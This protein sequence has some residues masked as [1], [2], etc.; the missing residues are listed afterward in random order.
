MSKKLLLLLGLILMFSSFIFAQ[1]TITLLDTHINATLQTTTTVTPNLDWTHVGATNNKYKV[2]IGTSPSLSGATEFTLVGAPPVSVLDLSTTTTVLAYNTTYYWQVRQYNG[3]DVELANA[4]AIASFRTPK[5]S[6]IPNLTWATIAGAGN[7]FIQVSPNANFSSPVID[8][9][10]TGADLSYQIPVANALNYNT[11]YYW[12]VRKGGG[13]AV[14]QTPFTTKPLNLLSETYSVAPN[15]TVAIG[16]NIVYTA[17]TDEFEDLS[18]AQSNVS[19]TAL[20]SISDPAR[21]AIAMAFSVPAGVTSTITRTFSL[22]AAGPAVAPTASQI[23]ITNDETVTLK[24]QYGNTLI[25]NTTPITHVAFTGITA[26]AAAYG[27]ANL[28]YHTSA[29]NIYIQ[30]TTAG[31]LTAGFSERVIVKNLNNNQTLTKYAFVNG[32]NYEVTLT[33]AELNTIT[34]LNTPQRLSV[35]SYYDQI[36]KRDFIWLGDGVMPTAPTAAAFTSANYNPSQNIAVSPVG[37]TWIRIFSSTDPVGFVSNTNLDAIRVGIATVPTSNTIEAA[38]TGTVTAAKFDGTVLATA[39]I[40]AQAYTPF[41]LQTPANFSSAVDIYPRLS[42]TSAFTTERGVTDMSYYLVTISE[43]PTFAGPTTVTYETI[44]TEFYPEVDLQF[45]KS[46]FWKVNAMPAGANSIPTNITE[47]NAWVFTTTNDATNYVITSTIPSNRTLTEVNSD[48]MTGYKFSMSPATANNTTLTIE[49]GVTLKFA[50]ATK[51]VIGGN[52][53]ANGTAEEIVFTTT[54]AAIVDPGDIPYTSALWG[55]LEFKHD[56]AISRTALVTDVNN[57]YISG[58]LLDDVKIQYTTKPISYQTGAV[59]DIYIQDSDFIH[60]ENGI[61]VSANSFLKNNNFNTFDAIGTTPITEANKYA[62]RGGAYFNTQIITGAAADNRFGGLGIQTTNKNTKVIGSTITFIKGNAIDLTSVATDGVPIID[63]NTIRGTGTNAT[64]VAVKAIQGAKITRNTIGGA[65]A[66]QPNTGFAISKGAYIASNTI[67]QNGAGAILADAGATVINNTITDNA[68]YGITNGKNISNNSIVNTDGLVSTELAALRNINAIK[69]DDDATV[70]YNTITNNKGYGIFGGKI[71]SNNTIQML[72]PNPAIAGSATA[73]YAI[74]AKTGLTDSRIEYNTITNPIGFAI[75]NGKN[76]NNNTISGGGLTMDNAYGIMAEVGSTVNNN[77][78]SSMKG[79]AIE[80]GVLIH[81][82]TITNGKA[83]IKADANA[84]ITNNSLT[85]NPDAVNGLAISGGE[86]INFNTIKGYHTD[87]TNDIIASVTL[88]EFKNNTVG[89]TNASDINKSDGGSI[90]NAVKSTATALSFTDNTFLNNKY[91]NNHIKLSSK[92]LVINDNMIDNDYDPTNATTIQNTGGLISP[93]N[94][95]AGSGTALYIKLQDANATMKRNTITDHK[96]N[97]L[98]AALYIEGTTVLTDKIVI[99]DNNVISN[100]HAIDNTAKGAAVYH[101]SGIVVLGSTNP[102]VNGNTITFNSVPNTSRA[103][104][105][106]AIYTVPNGLATPTLTN[107]YMDIYRNIIASNAGNYA[108]YGVPRY[109]QYNN[110]YDN[111]YNGLVEDWILPDL[112]YGRNFYYTQATNHAN[113]TNNFWG[114][115]SDMGQIDPTISDDNEQAGVGIVTYQPILSGPST[116]TPGI[117]DNISETKVI[118]DLADIGN[119]GIVNLPTD[120]EIYVVISASDNNIYSSDFT[121]VKISN[122]STGFYIQPLLQET[123]ANTEKYVAI[124]KLDTGGV[125]NPELNILPVTGGDIIKITSVTNTS[126]TI[127]LMAALEGATSITPYI[128]T[129]DFGPWTAASANQPKKFTFTNSGT[130]PLTFAAAPTVTGASAAN[131]TIVSAPAA[132]TVIP[133]GASFDVVVAYTTAATVAAAADLVIDFTE[134]GLVNDRAIA[135]RGTTIAAWTDD[136]ATEPWGTPIPL[137]NQMTIVADVT[138]DGADPAVG[139]IVGAFVIKGM[140]EILRGKTQISNAT[141]LATIVVQTEVA[142]EEIYFKVWDVSAHALYECPSISVISSVPGGS[143]GAT[144]APA[145]IPSA[146]PVTLSGNMVDA[147]AADLPGAIVTNIHSTAEINPATNAAYEYTTD[148]NGDYSIQ[149]WNGSKVILQPSKAGYSFVTSTANPAGTQVDPNDIAFTYGTPVQTV[150]AGTVYYNT[151]DLG[152]A[153]QLLIDAE[154]STLAAAHA[155]LNFIGTIERFVVAGRIILGDGTV[156]LAN[157]IITTTAPYAGVTTDANGYF[158]FMVDS[159]TNVSLN[160]TQTNLNN[161]GYQDL[162][163]PGAIAIGVVTQDNTNTVVDDTDFGGS[164]SRT[165]EIT[166]TPGW[167]LVSLNVVPSNTTPASVFGVLNTNPDDGV[168]SYITQV[169]TT[170]TIWDASSPSTSTLSNIESGQG[171]YVNNSHTANVTLTVTGS[172]A[173]TENITLETN[174]WNLVGYTMPRMGQT[175]TMISND[176]D[177]TQINTLTEAYFYNDVPVG[178]STLNFL[179]PGF[180]YWYKIAAGAGTTTDIAYNNNY[181]NVVSN[182]EFRTLTNSA[183]SKAFIDNEYVGYPMA[184][185]PIDPENLVIG[186]TY[187]ITS[188][189]DTPWNTLGA[190]NGTVGEVFTATAAAGAGTTGT[191]RDIKGPKPVSVTF[192]NG[193]ATAAL[194]ATITNNNSAFTPVL[195]KFYTAAQ[196]ATLLT[197]LASGWDTFLNG[198]LTT[199]AALGALDYTGTNYIIYA[200][201]SLADEANRSKAQ[202]AVYAVTSI[203]SVNTLKTLDSFA[204]LIGG[205]VYPA[206]KLGTDYLVAVPFGVNPNGATIQFTINGEGLYAAATDA[207][208]AALV[209]GTAT[210]TYDVAHPNLPVTYYVDDVEGLNDGTEVDRVAYRVYATVLPN[211]FRSAPMPLAK[212]IAMKAIESSDSGRTP[213]DPF[214]KVNRLPNNHYVLARITVNGAPVDPSYIVAAY[215]GEDLRAKQQVVTYNGMTYMPIL[216]STINADETITFKLWKQGS[217]VKTF[218]QTLAS[219]PGGRTGTAQNMYQFNISAVGTDNPEINFINEL[220]AAYPNPFNPSTTIEFS[221]KDRQDASLV[222]YNIKG[223]KV[224][225]LSKGVLEKGRHKIVWTGLNDSG[226]QVSS[227]IYFYR[228]DTKDYHKVNKA[229]LLK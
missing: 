48:V 20:S 77:V 12:R 45:G 14:E 5:M 229:I 26:S 222:I 203:A 157:T 184:I 133:A 120:D 145:T 61:D 16:G 32:N 225:T 79:T 182:L 171:Y 29:D 66:G 167:N 78:I 173:K 180:G 170:S 123:G 164:S 117:V 43:S 104:S 9:I 179:T 96:G 65:A 146:S 86:I 76:I 36:Q 74:Q 15:A 92:D 31:G 188:V 144:R 209:S 80:K 24:M 140:K 154:L 25:V 219:I 116:T 19:F 113:V 213:E 59:F 153:T 217:D 58:N 143:V 7:Y 89:G 4:S 125:Y 138:I 8:Y 55:G 100:N 174:N 13:T 147:L 216:V 84:V 94:T 169:R 206:T 99:D 111:T 137:T 124:F 161:A 185:A 23:Q 109:L 200:S 41:T 28:A 39:N 53:I 187:K 198:V 207:D 44:N 183:Y 6:V 57:N 149:A 107:G 97:I 126:V 71:V 128:T 63:N 165:Q 47:N 90:L 2:F 10:D 115:R 91:K 33:K 42:W 186:E 35:Y 148:V 135:L 93:Y 1:T 54:S 212:A 211:G 40:I 64:N 22:I 132:L 181:S 218:N 172:I 56:A 210:Y 50:P 46:Y 150:A 112:N 130:T 175:R 34:D 178:S 51:L 88:K 118:L 60:N 73:N 11:T 70:T 156:P 160:I 227:G 17:V 208:V 122:Q 192:A 155:D 87:A 214:G 228:L 101:V 139:D 27:G 142:D 67:T 114:S 220:R 49:K 69:A 38:I 194:T 134:D 72:A 162:T 215:V 199:G 37:S 136:Y 152:D 103:V 119:N 98:G 131:F 75:L 221:L 141:G 163:A 82:N 81:N 191:A 108:I 105:A 102:A 110:I 190:V 168:N 193:Q 106:S 21:T 166:L 202:V 177:V 204:F 3:S 159:G 30:L 18:A 176:A 226:K 121:E 52:I 62:I 201:Q 196:Y 127:N 195:A 68:G 151:E 95:S 223:Q 85:N 129:Y 197:N 205:T 83:A 189:G 158:Y 224:K